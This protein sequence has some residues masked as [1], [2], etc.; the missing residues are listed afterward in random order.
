MPLATVG[1]SAA[2]ISGAS[3]NPGG[4]V[5]LR[6][7]ASNTGTIFVAARSNV[8]TSATPATAGMFLTAGDSLMIPSY[9]QRDASQIYAIAD[10]AGQQLY[11]ETIGG[12]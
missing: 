10:A 6:A 5:Q 8:T 7:G 4:H 11:W 2:A 9:H 12:P 3:I 1:T